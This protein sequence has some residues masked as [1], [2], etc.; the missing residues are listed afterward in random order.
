MAVMDVEGT[1]LDDQSDDLVDVTMVKWIEQLK[2]REPHLA[3]QHA[4]KVYL[5]G[6]ENQPYSWFTYEKR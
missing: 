5:V 4:S 3:R 1:T 6:V 2:T